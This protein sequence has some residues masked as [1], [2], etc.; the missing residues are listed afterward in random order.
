MSL[1]R[2]LTRAAPALREA[3]TPQLRSPAQERRGALRDQGRGVLR[4][5]RASLGLTY[6]PARDF[7]ASFIEAAPFA[8]ARPRI[9][10]G[11][12]P[13]RRHQGGGAGAALSGATALI[14]AGGQSQ[15]R[16]LTRAAPA[17]RHQTT[18]CARLRCGAHLR[19][20]SRLKPVFLL[21]QN[22]LAHWPDPFRTAV[23]AGGNPGLP[24]LRGGDESQAGVNSPPGESLHGARACPGKPR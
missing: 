14:R 15:R 5:A 11:P 4:C 10:P 13:A 6:P 21:H 3:G 17:G 1:S 7:P 18:A 20:T 22:D 23:R 12:C 2:T 24:R 8:P 9:G 16:T 19:I